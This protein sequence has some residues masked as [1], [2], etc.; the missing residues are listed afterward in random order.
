MKKIKEVNLNLV[1]THVKQKVFKT[2]FTVEIGEPR[3]DCNDD[4]CAQALGFADREEYRRY[5]NSK[6]GY[7]DVVKLI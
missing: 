5:M 4:E 2:N 6:E 3:Y 1:Q 7:K